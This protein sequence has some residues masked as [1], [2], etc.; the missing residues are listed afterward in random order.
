M[1]WGTFAD[2]IP[3]ATANGLIFAIAAALVAAA[4]DRVRRSRTRRHL[5]Q[6]AL[7]E[8]DANVQ[9]LAR[10]PDMVANI[11]HVQANTGS[12]PRLTTWSPARLDNTAF[13]EAW[14]SEHSRILKKPPLMAS[15]RSANSAVVTFNSIEDEIRRLLDAGDE[16]R[17]FTVAQTAARQAPLIVQVMQTAIVALNMTGIR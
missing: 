5:L 15:L 12:P 4:I 6:L 14:S 8:L 7:L 2:E 1:D 3:R 10:L 16:E 17:A 13:R 11:S 9:Y